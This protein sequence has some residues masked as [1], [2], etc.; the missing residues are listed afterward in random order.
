MFLADMLS[1][2]DVYLLIPG[3]SAI[4]VH[5]TADKYQLPGTSIEPV[6][7]SVTIRAVESDAYYSPEADF[8][9]PS[10]RFGEWIFED[11]SLNSWGIIYNDRR[12][13]EP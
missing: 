7:V 13:I 1:S 9:L 11:G 5:V 6:S 10:N 12:L 2:D 4:P 3:Q 8:N